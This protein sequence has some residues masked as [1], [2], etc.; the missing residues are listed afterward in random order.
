MA[1]ALAVY[2]SALERPQ[3]HWQC[4]AVIGLAR[5]GSADAVAAIL[6]KLKSDNRKVRV[7]AENAWKSM[8]GTK[9]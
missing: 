5:I 6:P 8:A 1:E 9:A 7:A 4:A 2:R 3:E